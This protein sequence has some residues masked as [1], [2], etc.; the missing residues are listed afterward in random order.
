[1]KDS[2]D[3]FQPLSPRLTAAQLQEDR[4]SLDDTGDEDASPVVLFIEKM[5][6]TIH[7]GKNFIKEDGFVITWLRVSPLRPSSRC[8]HDL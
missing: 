4:L 5:L 6:D 7:S 2:P 3:F 8:K 1:M